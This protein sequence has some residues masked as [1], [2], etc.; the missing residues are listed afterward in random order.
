MSMRMDRIRELWHVIWR[1][2]SPGVYTCAACERGC[3]GCAR[4]GGL[5]ATC[6]RA[7]LVDYVGLDM[8]GEY[9]NLVA[10]VREL[11]GEMEAKAT[12]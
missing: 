8:A 6:A 4:G 7:E 11:E 9:Y 1:N 10:R 12:R 2:S 3:G 5:C